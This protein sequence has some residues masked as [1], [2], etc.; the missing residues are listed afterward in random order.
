MPQKSLDCKA[1]TERSSVPGPV[2]S[3]RS[4]R[5]LSVVTLGPFQQLTHIEQ[6]VRCVDRSKKA[7]F[8][9]YTHLNKT[10]EGKTETD[11]ALS[12]QIDYQADRIT[13]RL[14]RGRQVVLRQKAVGR[15]PLTSN[16]ETTLN[17]F[18][19]GNIKN[20][21]TRREEIK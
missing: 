9:L 21:P 12:F 3:E 16:G 18:G 20:M 17:T 19:I 7:C 2:T 4:K 13:I 8:R 14:F 5:V 6:Y 11:S 10:D 1:H 15:K